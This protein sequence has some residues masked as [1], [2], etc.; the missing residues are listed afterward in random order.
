MSASASSTAQR[1]RSTLVEMFRHHGFWSLGVRLFRR[2][3]FAGK[4]SVVT[5]VFMLLVAQLVFIFVRASNASID[6]ARTELRGLSFGTQLNPAIIQSR[7]LRH[8]LAQSTDQPSPVAQAA[9]QQLSAQLEK[10]ANSVPKGMNIAPVLQIAQDSLPALTKPAADAAEAYRVADE[11]AAQLLRVMNALVDESGLSLDPDTDTFHLIQGSM[12]ELLHLANQVTRT[13]DLAEQALK[14]GSLD[15]S[16]RARVQGDIYVSYR[17]LEAL[18]ARYER[19][20]KASPHVAEALAVE[21][22]LSPI[23]PLLRMVR[24]GVLAEAGPSGDVQALVDAGRKVEGAIEALAER[25]LATLHALIEKRIA[26]LQFARN[27][28]LALVA[29]GL[30][31]AAYFFY[32]FYLVTRG[33]MIEV[34]RHIEAIAGGDL[35]TKPQP[36][37]K[38]EAAELMLAIARMQTS[39]CRLVGQVR[40]CSEQIVGASSQVSA[41]AED[42]ARRTEHAASSLQRTASAMEEIVA[43]VQQTAAQSNESAA[44]GQQNACVAAEGGEVIGRVVA[45][46][47]DIAGS[48]RK[49]GEIIGT[50]DSIAFQTNILALNAAVEAARAGEQGRGFAVVAGEVRT[51]AQRSAAAAR[52]I[53]QLIGQSCEQTEAGSRVVQAAGTTMGQLLGNAQSISQVLVRI[54]GA[55][56]EQSRGVAEVTRAVTQLDDDTQRNAALVEQTTAAAQEMLRLANELAHTAG[57]FKLPGVTSVVADPA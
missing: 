21:Q 46:M 29:A 51:L 6:A 18:Y 11:V 48:S 30:L 13:R 39:M 57:Q 36:W 28:Q 25:S 8:Q 50:I 41:G 3:S 45:T 40:V 42:L 37:G 20:V 33:G 47:Q 31:V 1:A 5:V 54:S 26:K 12:H 17:D 34:T 38:D 9:A 23:N 4:A 2:L 24:R 32:S 52:E 53:K 16:Q 44:L 55:A 43:T 14:A 49:I 35:S 22:G 19:V 7:N 27:V 56:T 15:A 10:L